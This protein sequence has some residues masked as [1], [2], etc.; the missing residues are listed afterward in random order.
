MTEHVC[1][2]K[3]VFPIEILE[4]FGVLVLVVLMT[5]ASA[6]GVGG[7]IIIVPIVKIMFQFG[8]AQAVPLAQFAILCS[9]VARF[10]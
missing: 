5:L 10:I 7:G 8:T 9:S 2:H 6:G 4:Y 1:V 3:A